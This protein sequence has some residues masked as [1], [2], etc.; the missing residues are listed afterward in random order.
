MPEFATDPAA[1]L[2]IAS[3]PGSRVVLRPEARRFGVRVGYRFD[4]RLS[5]VILSSL[6]SRGRG[7][8]RK[9]MAPIG[10]GS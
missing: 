4:I 7:K 2:Q 5:V 1:A 9:A 10:D 3:P 8:R 6:V